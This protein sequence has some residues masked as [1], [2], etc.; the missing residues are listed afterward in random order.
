MQLPIMLISTN[1]SSV[2]HIFSVGVCSPNV[3]RSELSAIPSTYC[4][5]R[6]KRYSLI[7]KVSVGLTHVCLSMFA[8][9]GV[10]VCV[11]KMI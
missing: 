6:T 7:D 4:C 10:C 1:K 5:M 11:L 9:L 8:R 3:L 2:E